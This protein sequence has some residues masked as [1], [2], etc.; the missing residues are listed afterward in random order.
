MHDDGEL[1]VLS[2]NKLPRHGP[3]IFSA[4]VGR[5]GTM[6]SNKA[7]GSILS[8]KRNDLLGANSLLVRFVR[9]SSDFK[10]IGKGIGNRYKKL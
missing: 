1:S 7:L 5:E 3:I 6:A 4:G 2:V 10:I 8:G 9:K